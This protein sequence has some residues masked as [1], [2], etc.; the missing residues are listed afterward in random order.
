MFILPYYNYINDKNRTKKH[1]AKSM[2]CNML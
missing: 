1:V 2:N